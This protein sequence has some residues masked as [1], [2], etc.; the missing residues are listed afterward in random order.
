MSFGFSVGDFVAA[1][2]LAAKLIQALSK[3]R[4]SSAEYQALIQDLDGVHQTFLQL[5][6]MRATNLLAQATINALSHLTS[7]SVEL[8][9]QFLNDIDKYRTSLQ[10]GGSTSAVRDAWRKVEWSVSKPASVRK[11][12]EILQFRLTSIGVL[13]SLTSMYATVASSAQSL[14]MANAPD[15]VPR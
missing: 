1:A 5:E 7:S 4:G 14:F 13:V 9:Q 3:T 12:R 2:S 15:Q 8:M 6:Q 10:Q 11:F